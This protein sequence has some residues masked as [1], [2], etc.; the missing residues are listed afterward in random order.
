[1]PLSASDQLTGYANADT[2]E[3]LAKEELGDYLGAVSGA[4]MGLVNS[5]L[6]LALALRPRHRPR[7]GTLPHDTVAWHSDES[8]RG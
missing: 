7:R 5:A 1:V 2:I 4:T 6:A 8:A 3:T